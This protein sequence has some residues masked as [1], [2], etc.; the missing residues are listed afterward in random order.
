MHQ[1]MERVICIPL[2]ALGKAEHP[3][4]LLAGMVQV[5]LLCVCLAKPCLALE[6]GKGSLGSLG[7]ETT[8]SRL[9]CW[10]FY[11]HL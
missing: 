5:Q 6:P 8:A 11:F 4:L 7:M 9:S 3:L 2:T 10:R 1:Q